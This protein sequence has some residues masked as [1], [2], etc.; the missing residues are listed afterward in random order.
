MVGD[1]GRSNEMLS[2]MK[3]KRNAPEIEINSIDI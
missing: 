1:G 3:I 2:S